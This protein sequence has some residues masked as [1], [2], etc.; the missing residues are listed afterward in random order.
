M[1]ELE[2]KTSESRM[3]QVSHEVGFGSLDL[4]HKDTHIV[5][6]RSRCTRFGSC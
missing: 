4:V 6:F 2:S 3:N 5:I 1:Q